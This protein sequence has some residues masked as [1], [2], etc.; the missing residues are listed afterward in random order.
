MGSSAAYHLLDLYWHHDTV[1]KEGAKIINEH[2]EDQ[3]DAWIRLCRE[4]QEKVKRKV[5][6]RQLI[7]EINPSSNRI[8]GPLETLEEHHVFKM[9]L[10]EDHKLKRELRVTINSDD[11]GV[12]NTSLAHEYFLL[13]EILIRRGVP[14]ADV[15][16][17]LDWLRANGEDASFARNLPSP[18]DPR[19]KK[20][21]DSLKREKHSLNERLSGQQHIESFNRRLRARAEQYR[22]ARSEATR[23]RAEDQ[24]KTIRNL[25]H[26]I[27]ALEKQP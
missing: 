16:N 12:F 11:P 24:E 20:I 2:M 19:I 26:R 23:D 25:K 22:R 7:V 9:T 13:G 21:L 6:E 17:W 3:K 1:R 8:V 15:E 4:V 10:D 5:R 14:E 27:E 18:E